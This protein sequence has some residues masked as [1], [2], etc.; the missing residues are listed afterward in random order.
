MKSILKKVAGVVLVTV[1][2]LGMFSCSFGSDYS[3]KETV[4]TPEFSVESSAVI[5]GTEVTISCATE[6]AKIYYTTDGTEPTA[7][8]TEYKAAII[9][10][11]PM[12]LKAIAVKDGMNNSAVASANYTI[13]GTVAIPVF[14]VASGA[15]NSGTS[16]IISCATEGAKIY[17]TTD[18][19][20]P[21]AKSTEYKAAISVTEAVT[22]KAI[23]VKIGMNNS[24]VAS[25]SYTIKG[26][27][28]IP[29][30]SVESGAVNSGTSVSIT[31][32]TEGAKI[33]YT[34]DGS[35][36]TSS[37]TEYTGA[38][39]V[40]AAVT[41]KAIAVKD[42]MNISAVASANYTI[43]ETVAI[44]VF[45]VASGAVNSGTSVSITCATEG[46]KIYYTTDG[47]N[48]TSSSTEYK[49][50]ISVTAAVTLKAIAVKTGMNNSAV[51][52]A[53]YTIKGTV[54]IPV[55]SVESGAVNSGTSVS[56]TCATEG[57]KI[58]Y[59][60][61]GTEP[62]ASSKEYTAAI[63]VTEAVT[64]KAIAVKDGMNNSAVAS[65]NYTIKGTVAIPIFSVASGAVNSGTSVTI[66]CATQGAKIYYTTDGTE[67]TA[68]STEYTAAISVTE[69]VT[70][71]AIA[72]KDGMNNSAVASAN[73][74]IKG[75]VAIPIFSVASGAVNSG[76]NV[77]IT[78]A[79]EGAKIYYT[80]DGT[81]PTSSSTEY[82]TAISVTPPMTL[83]AIA[84][85]DGMNNSAVAS[86]SY[87]IKP[88]YSKCV[89]GD[90]VL[91]NGTVLSKDETP[92][93]GTVVAV[94]V[95]AAADGKP[96]L[97]VGIVHNI[98]GLAWCTNSAA[99]FST[100]ITVLQG[101]TTTD[102]MDGSDGWENLKAA[103]SDAESNPGN[104]PA[105]NYSLT[106]AK[107]NG[108]TGDLAT[109]WYLPTVAELYT[110]YQNKDVV[111][112]S[113]SKAG[114]NQFGTS[115][116]W[117]CCQSPSNDDYAQQLDFDE[118]GMG[119]G[120]KLSVYCYVCSVRAFN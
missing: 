24:A 36:P 79:T 101:D 14:S 38:I 119:H 32:A 34:T 59:T 44:P 120:S 116:Y 10:M 52:S 9:V 30:F 63:S 54:A 50:E 56:I 94:I 76:T 39:S 12:T 29:V 68:K 89:V 58:Y 33:Y 49:A 70:L 17:Y 113:L 28:A 48:P 16:V 64:L 84:V 4:A 43:K 83:K 3:V 104:Y 67:P 22:L 42:G 86:V 41:L 71:K 100:N 111:D 62:T 114:G 55:F 96:A 97:G 46:A 45:S 99:G 81:E 72:V 6:G 1:L 35:N 78:C 107:N 115:W 105:W 23:A 11:P 2:A 15:V 98:S 110:I 26:T 18:G 87:T 27:V 92:E 61:D 65:A 103:C 108:L 91:K 90:F 66:T 77:T 112:A 37:S 69:A 74:T 73:Y 57:A 82:K 21:T 13:K 118:G 19:T 88:D 51:A 95:R 7:N 106:Y 53:S 47:S 85:K 102:Y 117:S 40:I 31:C 5:N 75:T 8:S 93:S 25:A 109:G 80:T 20:E 60:T